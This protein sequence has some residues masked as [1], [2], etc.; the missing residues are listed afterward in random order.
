MRDND[1]GAALLPGE[2]AEQF[3]DFASGLFVECGSRLGGEEEMVPCT[4]V[5]ISSQDADALLKQGVMPYLARRDRPAV[6]L[7]GFQSIAE[8]AAPLAG[9]W[10]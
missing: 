6:R 1:H 9:R 4:E 7:A 10:T 8:P 3:N 2:H 5:L